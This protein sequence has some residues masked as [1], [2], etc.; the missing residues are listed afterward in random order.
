MGATLDRVRV[1]VQQGDWQAS[2]HAVQ[3]LADDGILGSDVADGIA[4]AEEIE[5]YPTY[6]K[7][8]CVLVLLAD[9]IGPVHALW[10]LAKGTDRPAVLIT[11]YRPNPTDWHADNRTRRK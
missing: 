1:L 9:Q 11:A 5:N 3:E 8:P 6:H 2:V 4:G 7:G 10:G